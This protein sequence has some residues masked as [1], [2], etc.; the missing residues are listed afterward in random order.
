MLFI[1]KCAIKVV[2]ILG[3]YV[4]I[5]KLNFHFAPTNNC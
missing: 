4:A 3:F 2:K 1:W 5:G